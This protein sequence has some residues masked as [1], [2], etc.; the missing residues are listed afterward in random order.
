MKKDLYVRFQKIMFVITLV[1]AIAIFILSIGFMTNLHVLMFDGTYEMYEYYKSVQVLNKAMFNIALIYVIYAFLLIPFDINK[2]QPG[3]FG[4]A[5]VTG[6]T[7][8]SVLK[9][10]TM[11]KYVPYFENLYNAF[12]FSVMEGYVPSPELFLISKM[13]FIVWD[14][15]AIL[16]FLGCMKNFVAYL[17]SR[18]ENIRSV[19]NEA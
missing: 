16:L 11:L 13:M 2:K 10:F 19:G 1:T 17:R 4:M 5:L 3:F 18:K 8:L 6:G 7:V 12:D 9:S 14:V 15:V